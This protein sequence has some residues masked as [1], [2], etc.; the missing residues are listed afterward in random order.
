MI[1]LFTNTTLFTNNFKLLITNLQGDGVVHSYFLF[2]SWGTWAFKVYLVFNFTIMEFK[3]LNSDSGIKALNEYMIGRSY[4]TGVKPTQNDL[5]VFRALSS[6]CSKGTDYVNV[7]RWYL[8]I[9]SFSS[10]EMKTFPSGEEKIKV[11][12]PQGSEVKCD[13]SYGQ[14]LIINVLVFVCFSNRLSVWFMVTAPSIIWS[15]FSCQ[16]KL[17]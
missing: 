4:I 14:S 17:R 16:K 7:K 9:K 12:L 13:L 15:C 10:E 5:T 3:N 6:D 1:L 8:H 2:L 11:V